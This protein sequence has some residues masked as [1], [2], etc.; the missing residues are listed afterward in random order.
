MC[1][2]ILT[3]VIPIRETIRENFYLPHGGDQNK[4][5]YFYENSLDMCNTAKVRPP[6]RVAQEQPLQFHISTM[7]AFPHSPA[8]EQ[9]CLFLCLM[10]CGR[11]G[12]GVPNP[13]KSDFY[14][15]TAP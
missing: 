15:V 8:G 3:H 6:D 11:D 5:Y 14:Y 13:L 12:Q 4:R 2:L 7:N 10:L 1:H 9:E